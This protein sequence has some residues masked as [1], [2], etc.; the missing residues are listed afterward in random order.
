MP[1]T[2]VL[3]D[4]RMALRGLGIGTFLN[5]LTAAL[6]TARPSLTTRLWKGSGEW[7]RA[8]V[9]STLARSGPFDVS[10]R[11]DPRTWGSDVVHFASN[12][13][14]LF[15]GRCSLVTVHD[16]MYRD[17]GRPQDQL[18]GLLLERCMRRAQ[19]V[20]AISDRTRAQV[21]AALPQL[22]GRVEVIPH[23]MRRLPWPSG[24]RMHVLAFGGAA[25]PRKRV[26][27]MVAAYREYQAEAPDPLPLVVLARAGLTADQQEQLGQ[28][29]ARIVPS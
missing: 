6:A 5:R 12:L 2:T 25:D 28:L 20:V 23:G 18:A 15:P 10:P 24:P 3:I 1:A 13:G 26:D 4:A 21:E 22:A 16:L 27:L 8:A 19:K 7:G 17:R 9:L 14:P 11:L 29:G